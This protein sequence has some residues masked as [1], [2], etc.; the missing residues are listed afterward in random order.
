MKKLE[1]K[2]LDLIYYRETLENGLEV[3]MVPMEN[4]KNY[5]ISYATRFGSETTTFTPVSEDKE[6]TVPDGIAHFLEHKMFEQED[7]EDPFTF[8]SKSGTGSNAS[9][10]FDNTRYICYGT[11]K[12]GENL[13]YLLQFVNA[14]YYTNENVEK[15]KGIIAEEIK[16]YDD[17]PDFQ[18]EMKLRE[19]IYHI[20]PRRVDIGGTVEEIQKITKE[21]LYTCYNNFYSPNNMFLI[22]VGN[23]N[24]KEASK[25]ICEELE[26]LENRGTPKIKKIEEDKSVRLK[27]ETI[28]SSVEVPKLAFGLKISK[29]DFKDYDPFILDL[30]LS[31]ITVILFGA[32]SEFKEKMREFK[33]LSDMYSEWE[34]TEDFKVYYLMA[35]S[36]EP[37]KLLKEIKNELKNMLLDEKTFERMKKVWI[38]NEVRISDDVNGIVH[39]VYDDMLYYKEVVSDRVGKIRK[40]KY[41]ELL[42]ITKKIDFNNT[43]SVIMLPKKEKEQ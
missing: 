29:E 38:A 19:N 36:N 39:N 22:I 32:G 28:Y 25:I 24:H 12:F 34:N 11:K 14:P 35:E 37:E 13:R 10:S 30:Y 6:I 40:L 31:M 43:A 17:I 5:F 8:Y 21:D 3:V 42:E 7:G 26:L 2:G 9:T 1:F 27:S 23:F 33:L 41:K 4:K 15:E 18:L 16:M 20:S